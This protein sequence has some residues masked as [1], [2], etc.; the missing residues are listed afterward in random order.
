MIVSGLFSSSYDRRFIKYNTF[1]LNSTFRTFFSELVFLIFF[2]SYFLL[3]FYHKLCFLSIRL[4]FCSLF[5]FF[6]FFLRGRKHVFSIIN[7]TQIK[8]CRHD[9]KRD[10]P[11]KVVPCHN[12]PTKVIFERHS[13]R[14]RGTTRGIFVSSSAFMTRSLA[15]AGL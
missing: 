3:I 6:F 12:L 7:A 8:N 11:L 10:Y 9:Y 2:T 4:L 15:M 5:V 13:I 1:F 14:T